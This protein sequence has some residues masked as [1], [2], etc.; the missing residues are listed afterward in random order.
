[1]SNICWELLN[2]H[3]QTICDRKITS[4]FK[5]SSRF[6]NFSAEGVDLLLDFSKTNIDSFTKKKLLELAEFPGNSNNSKTIRRRL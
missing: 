2:K 4:L 5:D 6:E 1:M 3:Y